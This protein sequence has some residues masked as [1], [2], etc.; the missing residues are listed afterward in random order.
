M[1]LKQTDAKVGL[2]VTDTD[3]CMGC[4]KCIAVCPTSAN[5]AYSLNGKN[6]ARIIPERCIDC[7]ECIHICDHGAREFIDDTER[8]FEDLK[9]G[10]KISVIAA[11]AIRNNF[12]D[13]SKL[14]GYLKSCGVNLIYDVSF[15]ADIT[16]WGYIRSIEENHLTSVIAQPCPVIV[17]YIERFK[18]SLLPRLAPIHSPALCTAIYMRKY[19]H[20]DDSIAFLSP[21]IAKSVEFKDP[22]TDNNIQYNVTYAKL[23]E[24]I[25]KNNI[26]L[27]SYPSVNW[28]NMDGS[29][30][31]AFSRPGGLKEN[32]YLYL[33]DKV[34]VKQAETMPHIKE[35]LSEYESRGHSLKPIPLLV[36]ILNCSNGCNFGTATNSD[37]D[38]DDVD[39][40]TNELKK[41]ISKADSDKLYSYFDENL[42]LS[43]FTR[44]YSNRSSNIEINEKCSIEEIYQRLGKNTE[45]SRH[46]NCYACGYG[47]CEKFAN[48][49]AA[50]H[51]HIANCVNYA[52]NTLAG[53]LKEFDRL[54]ESLNEEFAKTSEDLSALEKSSGNLQKIALHTK[55]ISINACIEAAHAAQ[56]GLS[57][58]VVANEVK[59]LSEKSNEVINKTFENTNN[60]SV[61]ISSLKTALDSVK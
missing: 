14:F 57:F 61:R 48:A 39:Y 34:W 50:G 16:T 41:N 17:S 23:Q 2:I 26:E 25:R 49:V 42:V 60:I 11:P 1:E 22:N 10:V 35:Y 15:G 12:K 47:S 52:R 9:N 58:G 40:K 8:F 5:E 54:F 38:V 13:Y 29:L 21:C 43:D 4:N 55:I 53:S 46:I 24:H 28:D 32:V 18:P 6:K 33:G 56:Y 19:K 45:E 3:K 59:S 20:A 44:V 37:L 36:D 51:N 27:S 31:M 30:G 7:G